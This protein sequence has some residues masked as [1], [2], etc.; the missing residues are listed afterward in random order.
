MVSKIRETS[1]N[2]NKHPCFLLP[3]RAW[4]QCGCSM[5]Q[6]QPVQFICLFFDCLYCDFVKKNKKKNKQQYNS[7]QGRF[8]G[9][10]SISKFQQV[11]DTNRKKNGVPR[12]LCQTISWADSSYFLD[13][14]HCLFQA[15]L[16]PAR[17]CYTQALNWCL[18][19]SQTR[20]Q[21]LKSIYQKVKMFQVEQDELNKI[22]KYF[23]ITCVPL[24]FLDGPSVNA[25]KEFCKKGE[26]IP[27]ELWKPEFMLV[28][29]SFKVSQTC[30][31]FCYSCVV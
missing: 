14:L 2:H 29:D 7:R 4:D 21:A 5:N 19:S 16:A 17:N 23:F 8:C 15:L 12:V 9:S 10:A 6:N 13:S 20:Q 30:F 26:I 27:M 3:E 22:N 11:N 28:G 31:Y 1:H 24:T 18:T 25:S